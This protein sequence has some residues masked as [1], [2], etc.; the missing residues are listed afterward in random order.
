[1]AH[2]Y[3][4]AKQICDKYGVT[5]ID[6]HGNEELNN[7]L[8]NKDANGTPDWSKYMPDKLHPNAAGYDVIT[9]YIAAALED[10]YLNPKQPETEETTDNNTTTEIPGGDE[11]TAPV[12][13]ETTAPEADGTTAEVPG[14]ETDPATDPATTPATDANV[15]GGEKS[16][17]GFGAAAASVAL[18]IS[19]FGA[20]ITVIKKK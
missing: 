4:L 1:M 3:E 14:I 12:G 15:D 20:A 13:D 8:A 6:L 16:C 19:V 5:F 9:P 17:G 10:Y 18:A 7:T 11:T 2:Y